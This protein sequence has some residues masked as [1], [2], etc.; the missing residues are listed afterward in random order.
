MSETQDLGLPLLAGAQA[1]KH[2]T[3]NEALARLDGLTRL[4]LTSRVVTDPPVDPAEGA[5]WAVPA[6]ATGDW[7]AAVGRLAIASN[8]GWVFA[9][10]KAG[11]QGWDVAAQTAVLHDGAD[12]VVVGAQASSGAATVRD[13]R[14]MDVALSGGSVVMSTDVIPSHAA[15]L[16]VTARVIVPITGTLSA[17]RVGVSGANDRYGSGLGLALN[18]WGNGITGQPVTYYSDTPLR[19]A[20]EGGDFASGTVRLAVHLLTL[21]PPRAV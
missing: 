19:V 21:T 16:G 15:V 2:I 18:S 11:W 8:G 20:A 7:A 14:V 12:W 3:V 9:D 13:V 17:F 6:G 5:V 1:Q 4:R 10:P